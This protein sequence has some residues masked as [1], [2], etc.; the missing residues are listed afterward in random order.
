MNKLRFLHIPKTAGTTF[1]NILIEQYGNENYFQF[2]G[3]IDQDLIN[4]KSLPNDKQSQV[5]LFTGHAPIKTG[6]ELADSIDVVTFLRD[7]IDRVKSF[8]QHAS[9]GKSPYLLKDFP[10]EEFDLSKF[11]STPIFE[12]ENLQTKMLINKGRSAV[13]IQ[14]PPSE[15]IDLAMDNL[16]RKTTFGLV[17][18]FDES[19]I[20][21]QQQYRWKL[22]VYSSSNKKDKNR[23]IEFK[24]HHI[25][26]I[27]QLNA[28]DIEL[29][30]KAKLYFLAQMNSKKFNKRKLRKLQKLNHY[31][32]IGKL[33]FWQKIK[34]IFHNV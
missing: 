12:L 22:P 10:P 11:L 19:L 34:S 17:E 23:L 13:R 1:T 29:Y 9:E 8:C 32:S 31:K 24:P 15:A 27:K 18:Y 25:D 14:M 21:F 26:K 5:S 28:M 33:T 2:T 20:L 3:D 7:P 4:F 6:L 30:D 16:I